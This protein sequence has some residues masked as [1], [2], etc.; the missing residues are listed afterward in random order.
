[1]MDSLFL[2]RGLEVGEADLEVAADHLVEVEQRAHHLGDVAGGPVH[3]PR[4]GGGVA[5]RREMVLG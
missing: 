3:R 1:M 5:V 2:G 4:D